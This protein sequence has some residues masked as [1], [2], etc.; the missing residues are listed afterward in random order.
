MNARSLSYPLEITLR[1]K[2]LAP[3]D[4]F[5]SEEFPE[6]K[7]VRD[8]GLSS[9]DDETVWEYAKKAGFGII[10]KDTDFSQRS[11]LYG[12][13]P[14]IIWVR[15]GNCTTQQIEDIL[16][17]YRN[18]IH[19]FATEPASSYLVIDPILDTIS[20]EDLP[21]KKK[22]PRSAVVSRSI[23]SVGYD[24]GKK[25]LEVEF[26]ASGEVYRYFDVPENIFRE[27]MTAPSIGAYLN[28]RI[29]GNYRYQKLL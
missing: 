28:R 1:S 23:S 11:F 13:P 9:A 16:R 8:V 3:F 17:H 19:Q 22:V 6:S 7:H 10:S 14:K 2:P 24:P 15:L 5:S 29:K 25:I 27:M 4:P 18:D 12:A 20:N 26:R 21:P